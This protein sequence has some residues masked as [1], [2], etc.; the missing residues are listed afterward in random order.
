MNNNIQEAISR[1]LAKAKNDGVS[2]IS[3]DLETLGTT[4]GAPIVAIGAVAFNR[5]TGQVYPVMYH[6]IDLDSSIA[7]STGVEGGTL[8]WWMQ[9]SPEAIEQTFKDNSNRWSLLESLTQLVDTCLYLGNPK[10]WGNGATFDIGLLEATFRQTGIEPP[11]KHWDVRDVRTI[12]D[13]GRSILDFDP[14]QKMPF[15]GTRHNALADA[16]HQ[17][18]YT[19]SII[20]KLA[21]DSTGV[22]ADG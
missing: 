11:W 3:I 6:T 9:Q 22:L 10:P 20:Q 4:P 17:A 8:E 2:D 7:Y 15:T 16:E 5:T 21:G 13:L 14:K 1:G 18:K 19:V 12:V